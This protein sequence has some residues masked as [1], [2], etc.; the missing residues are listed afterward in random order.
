MSPTTAPVGHL[1]PT[2]SDVRW[3]VSWI[4]FNFKKCHSIAMVFITFISNFVL[5]QTIFKDCTQ[6]FQ[7]PCEIIIFHKNYTNSQKKQHTSICH[8]QIVQYQTV[9][10]NSQPILCNYKQSS[11]IVHT[12]FKFHVKSLCF[13]KIILLHTKVQDNSFCHTTIVQYQTVSSN[14]Q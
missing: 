4:D 12:T 7:I 3:C 9:S 5:L 6:H 10:S 2:H 14:S 13:I 8:T 11:M 1:V